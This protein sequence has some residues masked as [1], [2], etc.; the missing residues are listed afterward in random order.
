MFK[1]G[2][3]IIYSGQGICRIDDI[4]EQTILEESKDYYILYPVASP[5]LKISTPVDNKKVL[6]M[7]L[8]SKADACKAMESFKKPGI[9]WIEIA[10]NRMGQYSEIV[11]KGNRREILKVAN[12]LMRKKYETELKGKKMYGQDNNF[13]NNIK[14]ILFS[15]L[16]LAF[17]TT[18]EAIDERITS[19]IVETMEEETYKEIGKDVEN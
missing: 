14:N 4:C 7:E 16:A 9:D 6:M 12:T 5:S 19:L 15:E 3:L 13:L 2:D 8:I 17:D 11:K 18:F 10:S 1:V